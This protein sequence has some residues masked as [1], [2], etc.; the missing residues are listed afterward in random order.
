MDTQL[1]ALIAADTA[2]LAAVHHVDWSSLQSADLLLTGCTGPFGWWLLHKLSHACAHEGL[3]L[4][5]TTLI[6]RDA[7][8]VQNW[9]S[10]LHH[11]LRLQVVQTDIVELDRWQLSATHVV[12]G[13]TTSAAETSAGASDLSKFRTVVDGTHALIRALD[14]SPPRRLLYLSSGIAYGASN[15]GLLR[16]DSHLAPCTADS[17]A[18]MGHAKRAAEFLMSCAADKWGASLVIARCFAFSGPGLPLGLHYALGNFVAQAIAG[19]P[20]VIK[21]DGTSVR[22][23]MHFGDMAVWL[24]EMLTHRADPTKPRLFNVG[25]DQCISVRQLAELVA[26]CSGKNC[27]IMVLGQGS[28]NVSGNRASVYAPHVE[29]AKT[30]LGLRL[31]TTLG[32]SIS[33]MM[34]GR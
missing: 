20:I 13:A 9:A 16:E 27:P 28:V 3:S 25:S 30:E 18:S 12:H 11:R 34:T 33:R 22:S 24:S 10:R 19:E 8:A 7:K 17:S 26:E 31:W 1:S 14:P 4:Q 6:T 15:A 2:R 5:R 32:E 23:Y 29:R 21:G